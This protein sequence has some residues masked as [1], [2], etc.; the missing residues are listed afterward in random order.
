MRFRTVPNGGHFIQVNE[1]ERLAEA[2]PRFFAG[3][4]DG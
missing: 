4:A 2:I 1:P 3:H